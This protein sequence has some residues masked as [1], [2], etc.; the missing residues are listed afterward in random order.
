M[1]E[2]IWTK[3]INPPIEGNNHRPLWKVVINPILRI[4]GHHIVSVV[5][6]GKVIGY[7]LRQ[8]P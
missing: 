8:F 6:N 1:I 7:Q 3:F 4:F 2:N 5:E